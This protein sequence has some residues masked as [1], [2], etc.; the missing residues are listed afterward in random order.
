MV[1]AAAQA[2]GV[3]MPGYRDHP[4]V[5]E[6]NARA[7][8]AVVPSRWPE[9]FGLTALEA[10]ASGTPLITSGRGGLREVA[11]D[12]AVYVNPDDP[13]AMAE[14]IVALAGDPGRRAAL[15]EAGRRRAAQFD[16]DLARLRLATLRQDVLSAR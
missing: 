3:V 7:A 11:G 14:A 12:A 16:A 5:L 10:L 13:Q 4:F 15:G 6:A 8:I 9:P 2:A 1:R